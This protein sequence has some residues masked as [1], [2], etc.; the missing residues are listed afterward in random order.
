MTYAGWTDGS[1]V[2][3]GS[4]AASLYSEAESTIRS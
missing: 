1:V 3:V 2:I 4:D